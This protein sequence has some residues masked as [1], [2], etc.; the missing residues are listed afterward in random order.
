MRP[1]CVKGRFPPRAFQ[2]LE[3][4]VPLGLRS[5]A[6]PVYFRASVLEQTGTWTKSDWGMD[7][8]FSSASGRSTRWLMC[9]I[10]WVASGIRCRQSFAEAG[11]GGSGN[12][13][14]RAQAHRNALSACVHRLR[15]G[16]LRAI[17]SAETSKPG[18]P[19]GGLFQAAAPVLDQHRSGRQGTVPG[20]VGGPRLRYTLPP[21]VQ[22][23]LRALSGPSA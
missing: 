4:G 13:A 16:L 23:L 7:G 2:P 18:Y 1:A 5:A 21:A 12:W 6:A 20:R 19:R 17:W 10:T 14:A 22:H 9:P 3:A 8:T 11:R 15:T